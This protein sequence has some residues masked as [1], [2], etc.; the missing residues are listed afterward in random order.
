MVDGQPGNRSGG[1]GRGDTRARSNPHR[2]GD[3]DRHDSGRD[4]P[5]GDGGDA[6]GGRDA[7]ADRPQHRKHPRPDDTRFQPQHGGEHRL[8]PDAAR[9][10]LPDADRW[11]AAIDAAARWPTVAEQH[12]PRIDRADRGD[13]RG[14][15]P[16]RL[17]GDGRTREHHHP[18]SGRRRVQPQRKHGHRFLRDPSFGQSRRDREPRHLGAAGPVRLPGP[19]CVR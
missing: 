15:G 5:I 12:R 9:A 3:S 13:P 10:D 6:R 4:D 11:R 14:H 16:L 1:G 17:R 7:E 18:A 8:W 2:V 19:G